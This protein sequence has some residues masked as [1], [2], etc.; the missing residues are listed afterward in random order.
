[1]NKEDYIRAFT[2]VG[3]SAGTAERILFTSNKEK[4]KKRYGKRALIS[5]LAAALLLGA[6]ALTAN[7]AT[8]GRLYE[9]VKLIVSGE[10]VNLVD[11]IRHYDEYVDENGAYIRRVEVISPDGR[12]KHWAEF[13]SDPNGGSG[14]RV[15]WEI[16]PDAQPAD[17]DVSDSENGADPSAAQAPAETP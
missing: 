5:L 3:P 16:D 15:G 10:K 12:S 8:E 9:G 2:G 17:G 14:I 13:S 11:F 6:L 4:T 1:M 7:A